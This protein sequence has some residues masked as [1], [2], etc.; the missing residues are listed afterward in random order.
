MRDQQSPSADAFE[1]AFEDEGV[2]D[3]DLSA[4]EMDAGGLESMTPP[5]D[6]PRAVTDWGTTA[7]EQRDGEP[8]DG[9][10][11][12]ELPD[13]ALDIDLENGEPY[14]AD[15]AETGTPAGRLVSPGGGALFDD[16]AEEV[17]FDVGTDRG[18]FSAEEAAMTVVEDGAG[19]VDHPDD[20][21][22]DRDLG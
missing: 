16:E 3:T 2:P 20:G 5:G 10:L 1:N 12:R 17:G 7:H 18:G 14:P 13:P 15:D 21:Y 4:G 19:L 22:L 11:A 9:R 8:L 6:R